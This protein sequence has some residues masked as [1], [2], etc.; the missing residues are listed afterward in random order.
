MDW[1]A[2]NK[3]TLNLKRSVC[4]LFHKR[5]PKKVFT[6]KIGDIILPTVDCTKFLGVWIDSKSN[7]TTHM[8]KLYIK[9]KQNLNLLKTGK[10]HLN[11]HGKKL[12][13]FGHIHSHIT[14]CLSI[15]GNNITNEILTKLSK[16]Q[17]KCVSL[18]SKNKNMKELGIL[19]ITD[20]IK[21]ENMKF[22]YKLKNNL[23]L[24][25]VSNSAKCD[26][27]G[28][29]LVKTHHYNTCNKDV[30]N[31]PSVKNKKYL[32]SVFCKGKMTL[33]C[34]PD[35]I[36]HIDHYNGFVKACKKLMLS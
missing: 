33:L 12:V 32:S 10:N 23:L 8:T 2:A 21:L 22:G 13:Y 17:A 5:D 35:S 11:I 31:I 9:L 14:Y 29:N 1:F 15:W 26:H 34:I 36:K 30:P 4:M 19:T 28:K 3:L 16:I 6:L 18:I 25:A 7:W 27:K 24:L 20:L